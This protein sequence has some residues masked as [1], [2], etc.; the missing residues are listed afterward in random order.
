MLSM[1]DGNQVDSQAF[2][3]LM[4]RFAQQWT[5][6]GVQVADAALYSTENLRQ[7][8][9]LQWL[10]RVPLRLAAASTLFDEIHPSSLVVS[11]IE[12]Y[13]LSVVGNACGYPSA[14]GSGPL[15]AAAAA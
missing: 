1:A 3:P 14:L 13:Q 4:T 15:R 7:I 12:G 11:G 6:E 8:G 5:F 2:G 9:S 10:M